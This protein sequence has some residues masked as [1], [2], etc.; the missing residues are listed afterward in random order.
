M[1]QDLFAIIDESL[2][3][4]NKTEEKVV[5]FKE[6][7]IDLKECGQDYH[8]K[9]VCFRE[10]VYGE[11]SRSDNRNKYIF[12]LNTEIYSPFYLLS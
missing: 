4:R 3:C 9:Y 2:R 8:S 7:P 12:I 6:F 11:M 1:Y 5:L 10:N